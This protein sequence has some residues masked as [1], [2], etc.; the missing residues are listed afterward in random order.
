MPKSRS[1]IQHY[2][3][4]GSCGTIKQL[5]GCPVRIGLVSK[6][7]CQFEWEYRPT[8]RRY[9]F[10]GTHGLNIVEKVRMI[11]S[12]QKM[13]L[14]VRTYVL[15]YLVPTEMPGEKMLAKSPIEDMPCA[16]PPNRA[17]ND[18]GPLGLWHPVGGC[19]C[20]DGL[21]RAPPEIPSIGSI[22]TPY[23]SGRT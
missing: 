9:L 13:P 23:C 8:G 4:S 3:P 22:G 18:R 16:T 17:R 14:G 10:F 19:S 20:T 1:A 6:N 7:L 2:L 15:L 5:T 21:I 11:L 12:K